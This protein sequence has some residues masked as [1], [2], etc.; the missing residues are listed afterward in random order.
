MF[1]VKHIEDHVKEE[2]N[3]LLYRFQ[4]NYQK[5]A[6]RRYHYH[7]VCCCNRAR[8]ASQHRFILYQGSV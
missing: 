5:T 3:L 6:I 8:A 4:H 2:L 1:H 7:A